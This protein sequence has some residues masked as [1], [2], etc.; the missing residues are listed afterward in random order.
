[1]HLVNC[2][3]RHYRSIG[4]SGLVEFDP[5][6][7]NIVGA[8][9][10]GKTSFLKMLSGVSDKVQFGE[11]DLPRNS[12]VL[13]RFHDGNVGADEIVQLEAAFQVED[14]DAPLL[15]QKYRHARHIH[16]RRTFDGSIA[17]AVDGTRCKGR[18]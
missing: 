16:V 2:R 1:M 3:V 4:D 12:E 7:T 13:T 9:G 17:V 14:T 5:E 10:S 11:G 8:A 15:P 6:I 18:T